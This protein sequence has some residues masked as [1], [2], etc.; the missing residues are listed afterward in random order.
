MYS[1]R[2]L[3][4]EVGMEVM[5]WGAVPADW[6]PMTD[7]NTALTVLDKVQQ[8]GWAAEIENHRNEEP[9]WVAILSQWYKDEEATVP[10]QQHVVCAG[11]TFCEAVCKVVLMAVRK[12]YDD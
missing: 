6:H 11:G 7:A 8:S 4:V 12:E 9:G 1:E 5:G 10:Y 3:E 2:E